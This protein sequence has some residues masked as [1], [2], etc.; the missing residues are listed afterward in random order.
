MSRSRP[1]GPSA[2]ICIVGLAIDNGQG[3]VANRI[4]QRVDGKST[5]VVLVQAMSFVGNITVE[6]SQEL[7]AN[8]VLRKGAFGRGCRG[9][10]NNN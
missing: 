9:H 4:A 3:L 1:F 7:V 5:M 8:N 6:A 10:G 2:T